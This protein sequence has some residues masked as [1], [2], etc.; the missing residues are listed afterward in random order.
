MPES[1]LQALCNAQA[2]CTAYDLDANSECYV[3][4]HEAPEGTEQHG[5]TCY[6]SRREYSGAG[7]AAQEGGG[8]DEDED[9]DEDEYIHFHFATVP[10]SPPTS[11]VER[12]LPRQPMLTGIALPHQTAIPTKGRG[13]SRCQGDCNADSDCAGDLVCFHR[14]NANADA[15]V[16]GCRDYLAGSADFCV[17]VADAHSCS[18]TFA[19][20]RHT[21]RITDFTS[22]VSSGGVLSVTGPLLGHWASQYDILINGKFCLPIDQSPDDETEAT[23]DW[24]EV[25][26]WRNV[27]KL[28]CTVPDIP[29]GRYEL[30]AV[31][32]EPSQASDEYPAPTWCDAS[33]SCEGI[34]EEDYATSRFLSGFGSAAID[35]EL[36]V[37]PHRD[38]MQVT[39]LGATDNS[40]DAGDVNVTLALEHPSHLLVVPHVVSI[41][42]RSSGSLG[43]HAITI[44]GNGFVPFLEGG[45]CGG[46]NAVDLSGSPCR[47]TSCSP[48]EL[49]CTA[50]PIPSADAVASRKGAPGLENII[51]LKDG[52]SRPGATH[53]AR[54]QFDPS[55]FAGAKGQVLTGVFF[56]PLTGAYSFSVLGAGAGTLELSNT[57]DAADLAIIAAFE[58]AP[59]T[60]ATPSHSPFAAA[61]AQQ[62]STP[63]YLEIGRGYLLRFGYEQLIAGEGGRAQVALRLHR[64]DGA[65]SIQRGNLLTTGPNKI[66]QPNRVHHRVQIGLSAPVVAEQATLIVP[67]LSSGAEVQFHGYWGWGPVGS[68]NKIPQ[69]IRY[70]SSFRAWLSGPSM[71]GSTSDGTAFQVADN[72]SSAAFASFDAIAENL[73]LARVE[74]CDNW[75]ASCFNESTVTC[76][77]ECRVVHPCL[78][79]QI[80]PATWDDLFTTYCT[81][82]S[83]SEESGSGRDE[84]G[85]GSESDSESGSEEDS[86]LPPSWAPTSLHPTWSPTTAH[87]CGAGVMY[88]I[89]SGGIATN[90]NMP[91]ISMSGCR[92]STD[93]DPV[94]CCGDGSQQQ[95]WNQTRLPVALTGS[96]QIVIDG[97][98]SAHID[99]DADATTVQTAVGNMACCSVP[100][101]VEVV[102]D[103]STGSERAKVWEIVFAESAPMDVQ[104]Y[105]TPGRLIP[106]TALATSAVVVQGDAND[107]F[108]D[109]APAELFAREQ[110][111]PWVD[112]AVK[113]IRAACD[114]CSFVYDTAIGALITEVSVLSASGADG[115]VLKGDII[116]I[117]GSRFNPTNTSLADVSEDADVAEGGTTDANNATNATVAPPVSITFGSVPC[118]VSVYEDEYIECV[119]GSTTTGTYRPEVIV[120]ATGIAEHSA[121]PGAVLTAEYGWNVSYVQPTMTSLAGGTLVTFSGLGFSAQMGGNGITIGSG[122]CA[123]F[124]AGYEQV[125]CRTP[126]LYN[127]DE[128]MG[129]AYDDAAAEADMAISITLFDNDTFGEPMA[130]RWAVTPYIATIDPTQFSAAISTRIVAEGDFADFNVNRSSRCPPEIDF[131]SGSWSRRCTEIEIN[132][133][134]AICT[135]VRGAPPPVMEQPTVWLRLR[136][137][138]ADAIDEYDAWLNPVYDPLDVALRIEATTPDGGSFAGG[139][140]VTISGVGFALMEAVV[141]KGELTYNHYVSSTNVNISTG[142]TVVPCRVVDANF[143]EI[144]CEA[145]M[146][147]D[148]SLEKLKAETHFDIEP[149]YGGT[150][151]IHSGG[152]LNGRLEVAINRIA[153]LGLEEDPDLDEHETDIAVASHTGQ[154]NY[155][156]DRLPP[157]NDP[158]F[159]RQLEASGLTYERLVILATL[160]LYRGQPSD[161]K[162]TGNRSLCESSLL[163]QTAQAHAE[164]LASMHTVSHQGSDGR[165]EG[166]RVASSGYNA[167]RLLEVVRYDPS[168]T[169]ANVIQAWVDAPDNEM[170]FSD[171]VMDVGL[172]M[173]QGYFVLMV[174]SEAPFPSA[175]IHMPLY[176]GDGDAGPVSLDLCEGNCVEDGDCADGLYCHHRGP[177]Q[178]YVPLCYIQSNASLYR[179]QADFCS[180]DFSSFEGGSCAAE[181]IDARRSRRSVED[182]AMCTDSV[183]LPRGSAPAIVNAMIVGRACKLSLVDVTS[184]FIHPQAEFGSDLLSKKI[185]IAG[186]RW[187]AGFIVGDPSSSVTLAARAEG[188]LSGTIVRTTALGRLVG[189]ELVTDE[190]GCIVTSV[191]PQLADHEKDIEFPHEEGD[192]H[193]PNIGNM[194]SRERRSGPA[195]ENHTTC[196]VFLDADRWY[197]A[198]WGVGRNT[199]QRVLNTILAMLDN[200][201]GVQQVFINQFTGYASAPQRPLVYTVGAAVHISEGLGIEDPT[202]QQVPERYLGSYRS[203]LHRDSVGPRRLRDESDPKGNEVCMNILY[204]HTNFG[205]GTQGSTGLPYP[206]VHLQLSISAFHSFV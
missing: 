36:L 113:S 145:A 25:D 61:N 90:D 91:L 183:E 200:M 82:G 73:V 188:R 109:P 51:L 131:M 155:D 176:R 21:P 88:T 27:V 17:P 152:G 127:R 171:E 99:Y 110:A 173:H 197:Y 97:E 84:S 120:A 196:E 147:T 115:K 167:T 106:E 43:G 80:T 20:A 42:P 40:T 137:C 46:A 108:W 10:L 100:D 134:V 76:T 139:T 79:D 92:C 177:G 195:S 179:S 101:Y 206:L 93:A 135:L 22:T 62:T 204:T 58:R 52:G 166:I 81:S 159:V 186:N 11:S 153:V 85:S 31:V 18:F 74:E 94:T 165:Y 71:L 47:I 6:I 162:P 33:D 3:H 202:A 198:Q 168:M 59:N 64:P 50:G 89:T 157:G 136:M 121:D 164:D 72:A 189:L 192:V 68:G 180:Y 112:V 28:Q 35:G 53:Y 138:G 184:K 144:V 181:N 75:I 129:V 86:G 29:A 149:Q 70:E 172:G 182:Q 69:A 63:V 48:T 103:V 193:A 32:R 66:S 8:G 174:A 23:D 77:S 104:I 54:L 56:P 24:V 14:T 143:S 116:A 161:Y 87:N 67:C 12:G 130:Y 194:T 57:T 151:H 60:Y 191:P 5:F 95:V 13:L 44:S 55:G 203:M 1:R 187:F 30:S 123:P 34:P 150:P 65:P 163:D 118:E 16:P 142:H 175:S 158:V 7:V 114:D 78:G 83:G 119:V 107:V 126:S 156:L 39:L 169:G 124:A 2:G 37:P 128:A 105:K 133:T 170:L 49:V 122:L 38:A 117:T 102:R 140:N 26:Q 199:E 15:V 132:D 45:A 4:T 185:Q 19:H 160:A 148:T 141:L 205:K 201:V 154:T 178:K 190:H 125:V 98:H 146:Y 111:E 41:S 9:E 96:F